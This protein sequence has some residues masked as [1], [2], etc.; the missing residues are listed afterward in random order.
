MRPTAFFLRP[1]FALMIGLMSVSFASVSAGAADRDRLQAFL[2]VTGFDVSLES[3]ALSA[4]H[5]PDMLGMESGDF[6]D[7]WRA[8]A[9]QVFATDLMK[10]MALD[11][12]SETL[13]DEM[14]DHA[15]GFYAS[16]LGK[17]LVE[18][19]NASHMVEDDDVK[20][21][22]GEALIAEY[23][24]GPDSRT[25]VLQ[26]L[27]QA[28]DSSGHGVRAVQELQIRFLMAASNAGVLENEID[29]G[30]L[31]AAMAEQEA[32]LR[33]SISESS[34]LSAAYTYKDISDDDLA[35]YRD[36]LSDPDMQQ[37]YELMNAIQHEV[38]ANRFETLASRMAG[39]RRGQDL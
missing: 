22:E 13:S 34:L 21:V 4:E 7:S 15:A 35:A 11:M 39:L 1:F 26:E 14:L 6:G 28:V 24:S 2:Q 18:V 36:A 37:V 32:E 38:M 19:E 25:I 8:M 20:R 16:D 23:G 29:E 31:R 33:Q 10:T 5:A 9:E 12:L 3:I 17:R 30:A 27:N